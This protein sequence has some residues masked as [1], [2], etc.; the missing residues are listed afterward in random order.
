MSENT[1]VKT[2]VKQRNYELDFFKLVFSIFV[3][4]AHTIYITP[5]TISDSPLFGTLGFTAVFYFFIVSGMMM[6]NS[7][8]QPESSG[9]AGESALNFVFRRIRNIIDKYWIALAFSIASYIYIYN[10][11]FVKPLL[12]SIPEILLLEESGVYSFV[13]N[14]PTWYIS[15]LFIAMLPL[16]YVMKR[17]RDFYV[18]IFA[19]VTAILLYGYM[20]NVQPFG[21]NT[22]NGLCMYSLIRAVLGLCFGAVSWKLSQ[23]LAEKVTTV[24][25]KI[26]T[27]I[28]EIILYT[29]FFVSVFKYSGDT[30]IT[31]CFMLLL[32]IAIA[33]TFSGTSY[34]GL[35]FK[36][37]WMKCF[38]PWSL[39]I[40]LTHNTAKRIAVT[41]FSSESFETK[42]IVTIVATIILSILLFLAEK[43]IRLIWV[44]KLRAVFTNS[45]PDN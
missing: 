16:A 7:R 37:K 23:Y 45:K 39:A 14:G 8:S 40:Y 34:V 18:N 28:A 19:P 33:I 15:A 30:Y 9:K 27:T 11:G 12:K 31:Y 25:A 36:F 10:E 44:K 2:E 5:N 3:F 20:Y 32:P 24:A 42:L 1:V 29:V 6:L 17:N 38:A 22:F 35:I 13:S 43:C 41:K 4:T 21:G 26:L